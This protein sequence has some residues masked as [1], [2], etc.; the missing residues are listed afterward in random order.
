MSEKFASPA[1]AAAFLATP[2]YPSIQV[3][4]VTP[5]MA[6]V[7]NSLS[8]NE[9][10]STLLIAVIGGVVGGFVLILIIALIYC[11][12]CKAKKAGGVTAKDVAVSGTGVQM[13]VQA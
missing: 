13:K 9:D 2:N 6:G 1:T 3:E 8:N 11:Y 12:V 5:V 4:A 7:G 10:N